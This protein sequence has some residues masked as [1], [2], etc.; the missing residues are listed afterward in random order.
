MEPEPVI[1]KGKFDP[2]RIYQ[3][4]VELGLTLE[5]VARLVDRVVSTVHLWEQGENTPTPPSIYA[6]AKALQVEPAY[7]FSQD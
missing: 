4:R 2:R 1:T 3:R 7:F 6:L 5:D